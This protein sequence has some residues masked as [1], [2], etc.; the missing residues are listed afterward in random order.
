V[1]NVLLRCDGGPGIGVGH[2]MRCRSLAAAFAALGWRHWFAVSRETA[3]LFAERATIIVP[4]GVVGARA[5]AEAVAANKVDCLVVDHYGLDAKFET[6]ARG[7]APIVLVIDDLADRPHDCDL[8]VDP[9]PERVAADYAGRTGSTTRLLL[10]PQYALLRPE[11]AERRPLRARSPRRQAERLLIMLGGADPHNISQRLLK[12]LPQLGGAPLKTVLVV[13]PA[14]PHR[15]ALA[16]LAPA[17]GIEVAVDPPD[18]AGLMLDADLAITT[19][20]TSFWELACLGVPALIIVI[21]DNQ[22]AVARA[23]ENAGAALVLGESDH[24]DP[25]SLAA[26]VA[27]LAADPQRRQRMRQAGRN[28]V[29]GRGADRVADTVDKINAAQPLEIRS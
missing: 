18:L 13:G 24:L 29:D 6:A 1:P 22:R 16:A 4:S 28:L 25:R 5:V 15:E 8:L 12:T 17:P 21:A 7:K 9:N 23:A 20:S 10:G 26:A 14:N 27:A 19:G 3:A 2:L 11:F